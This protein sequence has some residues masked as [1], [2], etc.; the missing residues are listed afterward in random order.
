GRH[1][2]NW[3]P[4]RPVTPPRRHHGRRLALVASISAVLLAISSASLAPEHTSDPLPTLPTP[5]GPGSVL[6]LPRIPELHIPAAAYAATLT[7]EASPE[8]PAERT[9][10]APPVHHTAAHTSPAGTHTAA[11]AHRPAPPHPAVRTVADIT[12]TTKPA[13]TQESH[14]APTTTAATTTRQA[15]PSTTASRTQP[16]TTEVSSSGRREPP[17]PCSTTG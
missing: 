3:T 11:V 8:P 2:R 17:R 16:P 12:T 15:P 7:P 5:D 6:R 1:Q 14:P 13:V 4:P 10:T 9:A